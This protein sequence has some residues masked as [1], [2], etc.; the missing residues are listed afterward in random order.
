M[1]RQQLNQIVLQENA[2]F[3]E[4]NSKLQKIAISA[5]AE[6]KTFDQLSQ[7]LREENTLVKDHLSRAVEQGNMQLVKGAYQRRFLESLYFPEIHARQEEIADAHKETFHWIFEQAGPRLRP[8]DS[9]VE[10]LESGSRTYWISGKA[11]SGKSTLMS[12]VCQ[13]PQTQR[14]LEIWS[15]GRTVVTPRFFF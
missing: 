13:H 3:Q 1:S 6:S 14:C 8:C 11:G 2:A 7:L 9:F 5:A 4:L 12:Y 10:W 15:A